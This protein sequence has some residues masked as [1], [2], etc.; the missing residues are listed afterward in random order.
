MVIFC[1]I[2]DN[3][4]LLQSVKNSADYETFSERAEIWE[5]RLADLDKYLTSLV[6]IQRKW[7]TTDLKAFF[8]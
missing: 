1:K 3:Q 6:Q 8:G 2:G 7:V 4:S 5:T